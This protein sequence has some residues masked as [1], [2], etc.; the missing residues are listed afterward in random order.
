MAVFYVLSVLIATTVARLLN[1]DRVLASLGAL[2]L[3]L[4]PNG[5][6]DGRFYQ[7]N[8]ALWV[9]VVVLA[10]VAAVVA[11]AMSKVVT[12]PVPGRAVHP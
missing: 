2:W 8:V 12:H 5:S 7:P 1:A 4:G 11:V 6:G 9:W 10:A 3:Q